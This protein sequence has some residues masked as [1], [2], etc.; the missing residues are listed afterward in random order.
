MT[1]EISASTATDDAELLC[2]ACDYLLRGLQSDR[3][4]E[5]GTIFDRA[6]LGVSQIPWVHRRRMGVIRAFVRTVRITVFHPDRIA[7]DVARPVSLSD[8][9]RFRHLV[10]LLVYVPF[11]VAG[12][13]AAVYHL[14]DRFAMP[15]PRD[16]H[17]LGW[18]L[19]ALTAVVAAYSFWLFL[20]T[21]TGTAS[22]FFHPRS[23]SMTRQNRAVALSDY[24]C[25]PLALTPIPGIALLLLYL[26][27]GRLA[28]MH[29]VWPVLVII[30]LDLTGLGG[31]VVQLLAWYRAI[32]VL[33]RRTTHCTTARLIATAATL[34]FAWA[35]LFVVIA[36]GIPAGFFFISLAILSFT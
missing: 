28:D 13:W 25:A 11:L 18:I 32:L 24:A 16:D 26:F 33:L 20:F 31:A 7:A 19:E 4:P 12:I 9:R 35:V 3:C 1:R 15:H 17:L 23:I 8:A 10:V 2:P 6:T 22:Y 34:P 29:G 21:A 36:V 14:H 30:V 5:C 27:V